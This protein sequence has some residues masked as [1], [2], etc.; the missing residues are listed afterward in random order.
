M[1]LADPEEGES[2]SDKGSGRALAGLVSAAGWLC[3]ASVVLVLFL[4]RVLGKTTIQTATV[5]YSSEKFLQLFY[6]YQIICFFST[7]LD[8]RFHNA[9]SPF[10]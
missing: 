3:S 2:E 1:H 5:L 6:S 9:A 10:S 8:E 4:F 7:L